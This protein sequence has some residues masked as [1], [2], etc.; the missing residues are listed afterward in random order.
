MSTAPIQPTIE[1]YLGLFTSQYK[2]GK[3]PNLLAF[4][5]LL[6]QPFIDV[7]ACADSMP[8][9]FDISTAVGVQ[10]D[11]L[12]TVIGISRILPF[13]PVGVNALTTSAVSATGSQ[14]V[15]V[16]NTTYMQIGVLQEITGS[17]GHTE[18]VAPTAIVQG[19]SFTANFTLTHVTNSSV[20]TVPPSALL[21]DPDYRTLLM[22]KVVQNQFNGQ[23][24]GANST[25][26]QDWQTIFGGGSY[27]YVTDNQNMTATVFL[28]GAFSPVEQ[29]MITNHLIVPEAETVEFIYEFAA[30]PAFGFGSAEP[31]FIAGFGVGFWA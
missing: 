20:T 25:L 23:Y 7:A 2:G 12:G 5:A 11:A 30:L 13:N 8:A 19:V 21:D 28:A 16:N 18:S 3:S 27:I 4:A 10:L 17:D 24:Q 26:W 31:T 9:A 22:A 1:Y 15:D 29:Q 14:T 6:M